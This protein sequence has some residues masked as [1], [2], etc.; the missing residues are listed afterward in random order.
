MWT[1][2]TR[3]QYERSGLRY[4]S[5]LVGP[6]RAKGLALASRDAKFQKPPNRS[7]AI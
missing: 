2:I 1:A 5:D 6:L 3:P 4:A 7:A